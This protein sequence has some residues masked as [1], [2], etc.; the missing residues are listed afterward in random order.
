MAFFGTDGEGVN[1]G[2][3]EGILLTDTDCVCH[4]LKNRIFLAL[5]VRVWTIH[6]QR[7]FFIL[8][9]AGVDHTVKKAS[10]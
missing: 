3:K 4:M 10:P 7:Q 2:L 1:H 6:Y 5:I 9:S 8:D